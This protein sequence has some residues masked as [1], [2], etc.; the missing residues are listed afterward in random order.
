MKARDELQY[1]IEFGK[2]WRTAGYTGYA[3]GGDFGVMPMLDAEDLYDK[4]NAEYGIAQALRHSAPVA[5]GVAGGRYAGKKLANSLN[6][7]GIAKGSPYSRGALFAAGYA[8]VLAGA[9]AGTHIS[10]KIVR[11]DIEKLSDKSPTIQFRSEEE[12]FRD[13][14]DKAHFIQDNIGGFGTAGL[15]GAATGMAGGGLLAGRKGV[16]KGGIAGAIAGLGARALLQP[17]IN[18]MEDKYLQKENP[19]LSTQI[20][21]Q[22]KHSGANIAIPI[23]AAGLGLGIL[24][25]SGGL[26]KAARN[27]GR[28]AR[29]YKRAYDIRRGKP[30]KMK[31]SDYTNIAHAEPTA[32]LLRQ[33]NM[34]ARDELSF[35]MNSAREKLIELRSGYSAVKYG[36]DPNTGQIV[37]VSEHEKGIG[38]H[39]KRNAATYAGG[40]LGAASTGSGYMLPAYLGVIG[41]KVIDK[42]REGRAMNRIVQDSIGSELRRRESV[43]MSNRE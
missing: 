38:A 24:A 21:T 1:I 16:I 2:N 20:G 17:S 11:S 26:M 31:P 34:S 33:Y 41:G 27:M 13:K 40:V 4:K 9:L 36:I 18:R 25:S 3:T 28:K 42:V 5:V 6:L 10:K 22:L 32:G 14:T 35:I 43:G 29:V 39:F 7:R 30:V 37:A 15:S 12:D 8:P 19:S 23:G